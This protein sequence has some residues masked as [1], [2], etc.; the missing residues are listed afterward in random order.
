[1]KRKSFTLIELLVVIAIIAI[2]AAMLLPALAKARDKARAITCVNNQKQIGLAFALYQDDN[3]QMI[4]SF[5]PYGTFNAPWSYTLWKHEYTKTLNSFFCP[6][7]QPNKYNGNNVYNSNDKDASG[8]AY[9]EC[10]YGM[11][12]SA[13][14]YVGT[15]VDGRDWYAYNVSQATS[16][17]EYNIVADSG[18]GNPG[19]Q[20]YTFR[21]NTAWAPYRFGHGNDKCNIL[22]MDS[23][24][25]PYSL[26][27]AKAAPYVAK[28]KYN[29]NYYFWLM[30]SS[31]NDK[32]L[33]I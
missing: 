2:L 23:H 9:V 27:Q 1:M 5:I 8:N 3:N 31:A 30:S 33:K 17:S 32:L 11:P 12:E 26:E 28:V 25:E 6:E 15:T 16:P 29:S 21:P 14:C 19:Y 10:T 4:A 18:R 20:C 24:V 13:L 22:F 7:L